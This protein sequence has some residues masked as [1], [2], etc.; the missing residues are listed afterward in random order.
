MPGI[1]GKGV[2]AY[3]PNN[4]NKYASIITELVESNAIA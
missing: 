3:C 4:L 2:L 1:L